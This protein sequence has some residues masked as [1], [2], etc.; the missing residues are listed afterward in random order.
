[1]KCWRTSPCDIERRAGPA[2]PC[3][4]FSSISSV[5]RTPTDEFPLFTA[6]SSVSHWGHSQVLWGS[7]LPWCE[8]PT[9]W[10]KKVEN[11][12]V[13]LGVEGEFYFYEPGRAGVRTWSWSWGVF[14][15]WESASE[16]SW[17]HF[18]PLQ[19]RRMGARGQSLLRGWAGSWLPP[20]L[21]VGMSSS[22]SWACTVGRNALKTSCPPCPGVSSSGGLQQ[23]PS[24]ALG[25]E[26]ENK[27]DPHAKV[28]AHVK[29]HPQPFDHPL[30]GTCWWRG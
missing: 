10:E 7:V 30:N 3:L 9:I 4:P 5:R 1:M 20:G 16:H 26:S 23:G 27:W 2:T 29:C 22:L 17:F 13:G 11:N 25:A 28:L 14:A 6:L 18:L 19:P 24:Q 15:S 21:S 8:G 12:L